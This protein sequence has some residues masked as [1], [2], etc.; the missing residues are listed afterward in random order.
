MPPSPTAHTFVVPLVHTPLR[1]PTPT[2]VAR[3]AQVVPF[4][5]AV[6]PPPASPTAQTSVGP[7]PHT[8]L[9]APSVTPVAAGVQVAPSQRWKVL[10]KP[11]IQRLLGPVP[12]TLRRFATSKVGAFA[13]AAQAV[14]F[15]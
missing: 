15:Q 6:I 14:P 10:S 4:Q 7:L 8:A 2:P 1:S 13:G 12:P 3:S 11:M 9:K 5:C